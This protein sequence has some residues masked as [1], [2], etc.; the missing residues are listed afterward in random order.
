MKDDEYAANASPPAEDEIELAAASAASTDSEDTD[1]DEG[2][3]PAGS[4]PRGNRDRIQVDNGRRRRTLQDG[5]GLCSLGTWEPEARPLCRS[6]AIVALRSAILRRLES[7]K[8]ERGTSLH[9]TFEDPA[10]KKLDRSPFPESY[11]RDLQKYALQLFGERALTRT[12]DRNV[13]INL[14]LLQ[15]T[16]TEADDPDPGVIDLIAAGVPIGVGVRM[17]RTPA[18]YARKRKWSLDQQRNSEAWSLPLEA[19]PWRTTLR[20][21]RRKT[22]WNDA[23]RARETL[24]RRSRGLARDTAGDSAGWVTQSKNSS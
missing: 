11:T 10:H 4:G 24:A 1:P 21:G 9:S 14:R 3:A 2:A 16:M 13:S 19:A 8:N 23:E 15:A 7:M 12:E 5:A 17:P 18:I 6:H 20:Q 22:K